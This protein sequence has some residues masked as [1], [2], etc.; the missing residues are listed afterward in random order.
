MT[1]L[2]LGAGA[3]RL[4]MQFFGIAYAA[5]RRLLQCN[6]DCANANAQFFTLFHYA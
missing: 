6:R 3:S 5:A 1:V 4:A 2:R